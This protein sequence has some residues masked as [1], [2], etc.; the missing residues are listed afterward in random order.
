MTVIVVVVDTSVRC[1]WYESVI[2]K[3]IKCGFI[4][5]SSWSQS[6]ES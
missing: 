5:V 3:S 4:L 2:C 1:C 6:S